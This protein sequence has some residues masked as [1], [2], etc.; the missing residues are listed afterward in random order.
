MHYRFGPTIVMAAMFG[1]SQSAWAEEVPGTLS[2]SDPTYLQDV[3]SDTGAPVT[4]LQEPPA[5]ANQTVAESAALKDV[6]VYP[7][8]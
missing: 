4:K 1:L 8:F 3:D 5:T 7:S 6:K 2:D